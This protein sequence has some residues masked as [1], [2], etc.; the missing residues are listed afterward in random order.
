MSSL[1]FHIADAEQYPH[2][3][4]NHHSAL[5]MAGDILSIARCTRFPMT[6]CMAVKLSI[7]V[8]KRLVCKFINSTLY[9]HPFG[10]S[11]HLP[12]QLY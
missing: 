6:V 3:G 11:M 4:H 1:N 7:V 9:R 8:S 12:S 5:A 10:D 2:T